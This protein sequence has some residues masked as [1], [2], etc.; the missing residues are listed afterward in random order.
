[1]TRRAS[2]RGVARP[3]RAWVCSAPQQSPPRPGGRRARPVARITRSAARC[4]SRCHASITQPGNRYASWDR[5]PRVGV[6][7]ERGAQRCGR[8]PREAEPLRARDGAA[9]RRASTHV[10]AMSTRVVRQHDAGTRTTRRCGA[11]S[12]RARSC[13]AGC[14]TSGGVGALHEVT[15]RHRR[16]ARGLAAAALDARLDRVAERV[17]ERRALE[18][19]RPHRGDASARRE[20]LEPGHAVGRAVREAEPARDARDELVL[21]DRE[22]AGPCAHGRRRMQVSHRGRRLVAAGGDR[23]STSPWGRTRPG[24]GRASRAL[25]SPTPK[26]SSPGAPASR[27]SQPPGGV[28]AARACGRARSSVGRD[29]HG[30]DPDLGEPAHAG[31]VEVGRERS[32]HRRAHR[33]PAAVPTVGPHRSRG[34][35]PRARRAGCARRRRQRG[36]PRAST[37]V[38]VPSHAMHDGRVE[39]ASRGRRGRRRSANHSDVAGTRPAPQRHLHDDADRAERTDEQPGQVVAAD[40][41]H[42]RSA[43][44]H[45]A[46]RRRSRSAL[47]APGRAAARGAGAGDRT[48]R[49][50]ARRRRWPARRA[51][52]A[53]TP[54]RRRRGRRRARR[55]SCPR[56]TVT[57]RSAGS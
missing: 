24:R 4:T 10:S 56:R 46:A 39:R 47:R 8:E 20:P 52:R 50:R 19:D 53:G 35:R 27:S 5:R 54:D 55:T 32:Q 23:A 34:A 31:G 18:L 57:V 7:D 38:V 45:D 33:D 43:R 25:G 9:A 40:V 28:A 6:G 30:A 51:D 42:R 15:E 12:C 13:G 22:D 29:V 16:R 48:D 3:G 37:C 36:R 2:L 21:V 49:W 41:L 14:S 11:T 44:L 1:M 26:P 17:V